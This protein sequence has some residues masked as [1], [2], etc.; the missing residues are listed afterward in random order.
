MAIQLIVETNKKP[1]KIHELSELCTQITYST[2][3]SNQAGKLVFTLLPPDDATCTEGSGVTFKVDGKAMFFG[4]VFSRDFNGKLLTV[5]AYDQLR[6][7]QNQDTMVI[8]KQTASQLFAKICKDNGIKYRVVTPSK[9]KIPSVVEDSKTLYTMIDNA[10]NLSIPNDKKLYILRDNV[11]VLE[12]T[13][14]EKLKTDIVIGDRSYAFT[15][16]YKISID[17]DTFNKI[18]VIKEDKE[19]NKRYIYIAQDSA[20]RKAW[21]TLQRIEK[22]DENMPNKRIKNIANNLLKLKNRKTKSL[23]ITAYG[24]TKLKAGNGVVVSFS[25]LKPYEMPYNKYF[26]IDKCEHTWKNGIHTMDLK[27]RTE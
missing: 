18:K 1:T 12:F 21:G 11:G 8:K 14:L 7:L 25:A 22:V 6:Y 27:L 9:Y 13:E 17:S 15:Y 16:D 20:S 24:N 10:I 26:I 23:S 2:E 3:L 19:K 5:T 4:T